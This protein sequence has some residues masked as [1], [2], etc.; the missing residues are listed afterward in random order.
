MREIRLYGSEGG[1]AGCSPYPYPG[2]SGRSCA[3]LVPEAID[4]HFFHSFPC[5]WDNCRNSWALAFGQSRT[6]SARSG[7]ARATADLCLQLNL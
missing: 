2:W 7:Q 4:C 1:G 3:R 6:G 5:Q